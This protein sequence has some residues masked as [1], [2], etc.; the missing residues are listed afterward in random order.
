MSREHWDYF[1]ALEEEFLATTRYVEVTSSNYSTHSIAYVRILL[2][3]CSEVE[4]VAKVL[5]SELDAGFAPA[6]INEYRDMLLAEY[7]LLPQVAAKVPRYGIDVL[8]W[9][10][11]TAE[12]PAWWTKHQDIKHQR[13]EHYEDAN[14]ENV[15]GALAGL[16]VLL[17][18]LYR[19]V[20][21]L[22]SPTLFDSPALGDY[23]KTSGTPLPDF[24]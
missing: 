16:F 8:P 19:D 11:W 5:C 17:L 18:Y 22:E 12:S 9:E 15:L 13:H 10:N 23:L 24:E 14:L 7:P 2:G 1:L 21:G 20:R 4:V 3:A 6:H